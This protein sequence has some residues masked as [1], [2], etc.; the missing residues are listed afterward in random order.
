ME[1]QQFGKVFRE[2]GLK[3]CQIMLYTVTPFLQ[4][5]YTGLTF[6]CYGEAELKTSR[7]FNSLCILVHTVHSF[8][9]LKIKT[10]LTTE[11]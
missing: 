7:K 11:I 5:R 9:I 1:M 2:A 10:Y 8:Y 6:L 4:N 3:L